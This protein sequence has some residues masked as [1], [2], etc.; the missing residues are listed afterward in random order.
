MTIS[1]PGSK[2]LYQHLNAPAKRQ[3]RRRARAV[4]ELFTAIAMISARIASTISCE[5]RRN[6]DLSHDQASQAQHKAEYR[7]RTPCHRRRQNHWRFRSVVQ[8]GLARD[9]SPK[10]ISPPLCLYYPNTPQTGLSAG[11][12]YQ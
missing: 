7:S 5:W 4:G 10:F 12:I 1:K 9:W 11:P 3:V 8:S 6:A 2:M